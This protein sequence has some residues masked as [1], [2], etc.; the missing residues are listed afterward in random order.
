MRCATFL[1]LTVALSAALPAKAQETVP[2][3]TDGG[4][5]ARFAGGLLI[6]LLI[7][8]ASRGGERMSMAY[9]PPGPGYSP[10]SGY[11]GPLTPRYVVGLTPFPGDP[12]PS[13]DLR[14]R[15]E[16]ETPEFMAGRFAAQ[17]GASSRYAA[18]AFGAGSLV[19]VFDSGVDTSHPDLAPNLIN[20]LSHSYL[21]GTVADP[22]GHGT[23]VA[24]VIA[25]ARNGS[26]MHGVAPEAKIMALRA[27][28]A[29][30]SEQLGDIRAAWGD[31]MLRSV[32]AGADVMNN[33]WAFV[34]DK[35]ALVRITDLPD[36]AAAVNFF[37]PDLVQT[38]AYAAQ[39]D[40]VSVHAAGNGRGGQASVAAGIP[41]LLPELRDHWVSVV[42]LGKGDRIEAYS[43]QC[44]VAMSWCLAA[45]GT[46]LMS[47]RSGGGFMY[48][49]GTSMA[50][51]VVSGSIALLKS[52][53]PEITGATALR[54]LK[55]TARDLGE[56][57]VDP[58]FGHGAI[59]LSA[60]MGPAGPL[61]V[62]MSG[63]L[64]ERITP[65]SGS[66]VLAPAGVASAL[67]TALSTS[68]LSVTDRYDRSFQVPMATLIGPEGNTSDVA[69][70]TR[71]VIHGASPVGT[72][73]VGTFLSSG[74]PTP[75]DPL[76]IPDPA[77]FSGGH[78]AL[79]G[80]R[81][82]TFSHRE[83]VASGL[84]LGVTGGR[85]VAEGT[86]L[87][88]ISLAFD[89]GSALLTVESGQISERDGLLGARLHGAFRGVAAKTEFLR[90]SADLRIGQNGTFHLT[91]SA[92][93][94]IASGAGLLRSAR[95]R[96]DSVGL[97]FSRSDPRTGARMSLGLS[98][99][100]SVRGGQ[101]GLLLPVGVGAAIDGATSTEVRT[102]NAG[103][104]VGPARSVL[105]VQFGYDVPI[106]AARLRVAVSHRAGAGPGRGTSA[107]LGLSLLF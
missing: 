75:G 84:S 44:G 49:S 38:M 59:D 83:E 15:E 93:D 53:F 67:A 82:V 81:A 56:P 48:E 61:S 36:R 105:D 60:A 6:G 19:S 1:L 5:A 103:L 16:F 88:A 24:G 55:E 21:S 64:N 102:R 98:R 91:A 97:G 86:A 31:A 63:V 69:A 14:D 41:L 43:S 33:S 101:I 17:I 4:H 26:G 13:G 3:R 65:L 51:P 30:G 29:P 7:V 87:T 104:E 80:G 58:V 106:G 23:A 34:D 85:G 39:Q 20:S 92:G 2:A 107:S 40:L 89:L 10:P 90:A 57:G 54:I 47:T 76:A 95:L 11:K 68:L 74:A 78:A 94:T 70:L 12:H 32:E 50:A 77:R 73:N 35:R 100:V 66:G 18:G 9:D 46:S 99:P 37:G 42:A 79:V 72:A 45:P 27:L 96:S 52:N 25:A 8:A 71:F 28:G 22:D 62:Q